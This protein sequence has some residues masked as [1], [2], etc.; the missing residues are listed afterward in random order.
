MGRTLRLLLPICSLALAA[1]TACGPVQSGVDGACQNSCD[2]TRTDAPF[3]CPGEWLC[4]ADQL[5]EY[6]CGEPCGGEVYTCPADTECTGTFC[7]AR[8]AHDC[9]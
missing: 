1:A 9:L 7:S 2:C 4:N 5:C 6:T 3:R 8:Q